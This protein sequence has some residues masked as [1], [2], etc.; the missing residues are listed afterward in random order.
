[1]LKKLF[2]HTAI[3][4]LAPQIPKIAGLFSL[5]V[6][7][8]YLTELDFG[9]SGIILSVAGAISVLSSLGLRVMLVNTFYKSSGQYKWAWRQIYGFLTL[10]NLPY[11]VLLGL[12]LIFF[13]PDEA[14][15]NQW[16]IILLNVLPIVFFGPTSTLG[17]TYY[18]L[19]QRPT[20]IAI[21]T[22]IFGS[23]TVLLNIYF[24][25]FLKMGYMGWF[26]SACIVTMLSNISYWIPLNRSLGFTPI[27]NFKWRLIKN[28]LSVSLPTV[29]HY[30]SSY[31]LDSSDRIVM[32]LFKVPTGNIGIYNAAYTVGNLMQQVGLASGLAVGP[33]MNAAYKKNNDR[34]ARNLVFILQVAFFA[35][36]FFASLWL[37]EIF[38]FLIKNETLQ[39]AY[40][41]GIIIIMAYNYRPM[42][43]GAN[44]KLM[45]LEKTK[46]LLK[47]TFIAGL[48]NV[49][50]N[51]IF[52][53]LYGYQVAAYTTFAALMYMGYAGYFV[54]V[55]KEI[56]TA[57]YF[58]L[59]WLAATVLL[60]IAA[61]LLVEVPVGFKIIISLVVAIVAWTFIRKF[62]N[63]LK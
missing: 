18:Q 25:A 46:L 38:L 29:P 48:I 51:C 4:G 19:K 58:P 17:T 42:Y 54:K 27:F 45:Y 49:I 47:V 26:L 59:L 11:A 5:P 22:I 55:F 32:S 13:I 8:K 31:L 61:Y 6:I 56:N 57:E 60:T 50:L 39:Q 1:M 23:L 15:H 12:I 2:S 43:F 24:I 33:L 28:Y 37:K 35:I 63:E 34:E 9:V 14:R 36:T 52:I 10:W 44:T 7:T 16:W 41:L 62:N 21:R 40:P 3:Y 20:Q 30:Y 53:P